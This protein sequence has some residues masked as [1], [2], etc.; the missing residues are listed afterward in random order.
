MNVTNLLCP[1]KIEINS[2]EILNFKF[3]FVIFII[4]FGST[5]TSQI[6]EVISSIGYENKIFSWDENI[7]FNLCSG[8]V[9]S[10][11]PVL[12]TEVNHQPYSSRYE[13]IK[14][15]EIPILGICFGHQLLGIIYGAN[16]YKGKA[17]RNPVKIQILKKEDLF[18]NFNDSSV[19]AQDHTEGINLPKDFIHLARSDDYEIEAMKHSFKFIYGVQFH[20]EI[21]E[22]NGKVLLKNFCSISQLGS[23]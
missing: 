12:L 18:E 9:F 10:G 14:E 3:A 5:K 11:A 1:S 16:V 21:S 19:F 7:N 13:F 6:S 23:E 2:K 15:I 22:N 17:I 20:P 8:I 4:D